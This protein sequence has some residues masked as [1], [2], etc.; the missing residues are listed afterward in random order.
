MIN[1]SNL[2]KEFE[3]VDFFEKIET[4]IDKNANIKKNENDTFNIELDNNG[5]DFEKSMDFLL[6]INNE[7]FIIN[8]QSIQILSSI[9]IDY[10]IYKTTFS[11]SE[12]QTNNFSEQN[13]FYRLIIPTVKRVTFHNHFDNLINVSNHKSHNSRNGIKFK[14]EN[15][16]LYLYYL[17]NYL[18]I[19]NQNNTKFEQFDKYCRI[20]LSGV[21]FITG[22]IPMNYGYYFS[23]ESLDGF[24]TGY[25]FTSSF[26]NN[27]KSSY[28][29][30]D[31][32]AH[33][34]YSSIDKKEYFK[35]YKIQVGYLTEELSKKLTPISYKIFSNLCAKMLNKNFSNIIFSILSV[36]NYDNNQ[37]LTLKGALYSVV[38]EMTTNYICENNKEKLFFIKDKTK[39]RN[40]SKLL[41]N[42][43]IKFFNENQLDD[44]KDSPID[45]RLSNINSPTNNDKLTKPFELMDIKLTNFEK[46][47]LSH[48]NDFL[49]GND[50]LNIENIYNLSHRLLYIN[51]ELN[52]LI[53][54]LLLKDIGYKGYVKNLSKKY[55]D[56]YKIEELKNQEYFKI[57]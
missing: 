36:N 3:I 54:A 28:N 1:K 20:S 24:F 57:L 44:F 31:L 50:F 5:L 51:L 22:Y 7:I 46:Q 49:H 21:G 38:L 37:D 12:F 29:L 16:E 4:N 53:N 27:Y 48:R 2:T 8:N 19:E 23:L 6:N 41:K 40:F 13:N 42:N 39:R 18:V 34:Y 17:D 33:N 52:Y 56:K 55:L 47:I 11:I 9:Q 45:K 14:I 26:I 15:I 32:N 25:K 43:A 30:I 10:N 35:K